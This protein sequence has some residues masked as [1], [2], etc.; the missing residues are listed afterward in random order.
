M[1]HPSGPHAMLWSE[2]VLPSPDC[3]FKAVGAGSS[4]GKCKNITQKIN[5]LPCL[6]CSSKLILKTKVSAGLCTFKIVG[7]AMI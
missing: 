1:G 5:W 3:R 2:K 6:G 7:E 4:S